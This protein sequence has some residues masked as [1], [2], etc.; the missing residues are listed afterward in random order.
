MQELINLY[1]SYH[2][3]LHAVQ[4]L[5]AASIPYDHISLI[6]LNGKRK[7]TDAI[8][9]VSKQ[10]V[11]KKGA[12]PAPVIAPV[13]EPIDLAPHLKAAF[14]ATLDLKELDG[15][16]EVIA[17]GWLVASRDDLGISD[18]ERVVDIMV[19]TGV[20]HEHAETYIEG[21]RRGGT[22]LGVRAEETISETVMRILREEHRPLD[23]HMRGHHYWQ[24]DIKTSRDLDTS[25]ANRLLAALITGS[26]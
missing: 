8:E 12:K 4:E 7:K 1:E 17:A 6:A 16:G 11:T 25:A 22:L 20:S 23:P 10:A 9:E 13:P 14:F 21:I 24:G 5:E 2:E 3:A 18:I 15:I 19:E 26:N